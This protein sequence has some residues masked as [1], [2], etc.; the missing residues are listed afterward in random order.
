MSN[1][2]ARRANEHPAQGNALGEAT[3]WENGAGRGV[4]FRPAC[5]IG[6]VNRELSWSYH[7]TITESIGGIRE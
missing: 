1:G 6:G 5:C 2:A 7:G 4:A 3:V